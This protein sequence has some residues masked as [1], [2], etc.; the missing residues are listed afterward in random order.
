MTKSKYSFGP[1]AFNS[2][3]AVKVKAR[4]VREATETGNQLIGDNLAFLTEL[5]HCHISAKEKIGS[6]IK[7]IYVDSAP[8]WEGTC[9]WVRRTDGTTTDFGAKDVKANALQMAR[10]GEEIPG[11]SL[12]SRSGKRVVTSL[13]DAWEIVHGEF[14]LELDS[15]LTSCNIKITDLEKAVRS[16]AEKGKGA[17]QLRKLN[18]RF[19]ESGIT[20]T[21]SDI[22]YLHKNKLKD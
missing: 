15:F 6:G 10:E 13:L 22:E 1:F 7:S 12:K 14:G 20:K 19:A 9:F 21:L 5:L 11:Y 8:D 3:A 16:G 4:E 2:K 18:S 17:E